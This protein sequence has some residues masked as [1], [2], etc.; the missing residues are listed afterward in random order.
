M[1]Q[2]ND[3]DPPNN[4]TLDALAAMAMKSF[5][6]SWAYYSPYYPTATF[7]PSTWKGC[8]VSQVNI[9]SYDSHLYSVH[10]HPVL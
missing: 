5:S 6:E 2:H 4:G 3:D 1:Q 9:V 10:I 8:V 7:E